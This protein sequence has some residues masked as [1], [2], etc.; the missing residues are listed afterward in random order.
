[1]RSHGKELGLGRRLGVTTGTI[2]GGLSVLLMLGVAA[3]ND[4]EPE[5]TAEST[6][7]SLGPTASSTLT[8][9]ETATLISTDTDGSDATV[10]EQPFPGLEKLVVSSDASVIGQVEEVSELRTASRRDDPS[11]QVAYYEAS[12]KVAQIIFGYRYARVDRHLS[13]YY[14]MDG[15]GSI[16]T[17]APP[18][19]RG[20]TVLLFLTRDQSLFGPDDTNLV[21][22]DG[23][24]AWGKFAVGDGHVTTLHLAEE[25]Q[26]LEEVTAWIEASRSSLARP[27]LLAGEV[28]GLDEGDTAAM[29]LMNLGRSH[30]EENGV[31]VDEWTLG[32]GPWEQRGLR[33]S[34]G[35]YHLVS[36]AEGYLP[37]HRA[38]GVMFEVPAEGMDW[39]ERNL[40]FAFF[41]PKDASDRPLDTGTGWRSERSVGG[42]IDAMADG[43]EATVRIQRLPPVPNELYVV[44]PPLP[45]DTQLYYP[46]EL[47]CLEEIGHLEPEET[48]AVVEVHNGRWG[49]SDFA[50][51]GNRYLITIEAS[52]LRGDPVGYVAVLFGGTAE[53][54]LRGVDFHVGDSESPDC[55]TGPQIV[56]PA[57]REALRNIAKDPMAR[58][59]ERVPGFGGAFRDTDR[60]IVYIYLQDASMQKEAERA[61]TEEFG[62]DFL[63][64][65]EVQVLK[66]DYSMDHLDA[67]YR[68]LSGAISQVPG[69]VYTDLDEGKNRIEIVMYP[70]R[71]GREEMGAA[72]A[73]VDVPRGAV[74]ID[75]GCEGKWPRDFGEPPEEAFL[76]AVEY[77]LEVVSQVPYGETVE[78]KLTLRNAGD[79]PVSFLLGG[80]PPYDFVFSTADGE[81]VWHWMCAKITLLS[82][83][84]ETLEPV[85][86]WSSSASG[87][88]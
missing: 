19:E 75:V 15:D 35:T 4:A 59:A 83:G 63:A 30:R 18:M 48:V 68:T 76:Q 14:V 42:R 27:G 24:E 86:S 70:R 50:L 60:N 11:S 25:S 20:E 46:P 77:S 84:P 10:G 82:L 40:G 64:G 61:L 85:R 2:I 17:I 28:S 51:E 7:S 36:E 52:G 74:V 38:G 69:I 87:S 8:P 49:L 58:I 1:M 71:G 23:D 6:I 5:T 47:T 72:I 12:V 78:M 22:T 13:V 32:N 31:L 26:P 39:R 3:C 54:L 16:P 33:L 73:T 56:E 67:W 65:R 55:G 37:L 41:R 88:R 29:R 53:H 44:G 43:V 57:V 62:S 9:T 21:I 34:Q 80:S 81:L 45:E 66:G 79:E